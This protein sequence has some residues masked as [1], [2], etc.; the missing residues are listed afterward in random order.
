[1]RLSYADS[2]IEILLYA[3]KALPEDLWCVDSLPIFK[4]ADAEKS[5]RE[6]SPNQLATDTIDDVL[7]VPLDENH[8]T[9]A[10]TTATDSNKCVEDTT[11]GT[12]AD[13]KRLLNDD[14]DWFTA[15]A[16]ELQKRNETTPSHR[17]EKHR[18]LN[19]QR[20]ASAKDERSEITVNRIYHMT[21][22]S[23]KINKFLIFSRGK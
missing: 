20:R 6:S 8:G 7:A 4:R 22:K 17:P 3:H 21:V 9:A 13:I 12:S 18:Y 11:S 15:N 23:M 2:N 14:N 16:D 5:A 10:D 19:K 1:M